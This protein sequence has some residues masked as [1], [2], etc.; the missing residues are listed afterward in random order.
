MRVK[1]GWAAGA[2]PHALRPPTPNPTI[3]P[4]LPCLGLDVVPGD[5]V[6]HGAQGG[7]QHARGL[8]HE[9]LDEAAAHARVDDLLNFVVGAVRQVGQG[10]AGVG[11][12]FVV[13]GVHQLGQGGQG[14]AHLVKRGLRLAPAKVGQRPRRVAHLGGTGPRDGH[15]RGG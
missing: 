10:P 8:V 9:Q 5:H 1:R 13:V 7:D 15:G 11:Q 6:A 2:R 4:P 3:H 14:Q 12:D